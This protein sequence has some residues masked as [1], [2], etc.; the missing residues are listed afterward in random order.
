M[1]YV[2]AEALQC[3]MGTINSLHKNGE[4][5]GTFL[6]LLKEHPQSQDTANLT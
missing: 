5:N 6:F 1:F 2:S 4:K 3:K